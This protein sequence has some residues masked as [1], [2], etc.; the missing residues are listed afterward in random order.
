MALVTV[1]YPSNVYIPLS[2]CGEVYLCLTSEWDAL[3]TSGIGLVLATVE[4]T[5]RKLDG[6]VIPGYEF[7]PRANDVHQYVFTYDD[8]QITDPVTDVIEC[9]DIVEVIPYSC[10]VGKLLAAIEALT[11]P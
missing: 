9:A 6:H 3:T 11:P 1:T 4:N 5:S 7:D 8:T 2:A 10:T